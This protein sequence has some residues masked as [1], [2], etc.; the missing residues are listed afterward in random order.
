MFKKFGLILIIICLLGSVAFA[1]SFELFVPSEEEVYV[2]ES[3]NS[4]FDIDN[5]S[6]G[7]YSISFDRNNIE[8]NSINKVDVYTEDAYDSVTVDNLFVGDNLL[9]AGVPVTIESIVK[10]NDYALING[11]VYENGIDMRWDDSELLWRIVGEDDYGSYTKRGTK[12]FVLSD[13]VVFD[14]YWDLE[15]GLMFYEGV[16]NVVKAI[17][18]SENDSFTQYNTVIELTD[19]EIDRIVRYYVP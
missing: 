18:E 15:A 7:L 4:E 11:G 1:D 19:D 2:Y 14:D 12:S 10:D 3:A 6:N 8:G 5:M 16:D 9:V 13:N 17:M